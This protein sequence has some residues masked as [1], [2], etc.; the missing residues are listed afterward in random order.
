MENIM[1]D[2]K[3]TNDFFKNAANR[4]ANQANDFFKAFGDFSMPS[5]D[6]N[7]LFS[8]ARRNMEAC[9][10]AHQVM[11]EGVQAVNKRAAEVM[12]S[13]V[14]KCMSMSRDM[15]SSTSPEST[16]KKQSDAAKEVFESCVNSAREI[17]EMVSKST[18][19]AFDVL[20]KR[21]AEAM[22]EGS[23]LAKKAA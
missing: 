3:Q 16:S 5:I 8:L 14:E 22:E 21:A 15:M 7:D 13:N 6:F 11:I 4:Q 2:T 23:K 12:Q 19:E 9:S 17:S 10:A 1:A 18:F 20:N